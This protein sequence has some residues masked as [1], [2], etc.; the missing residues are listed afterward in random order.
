MDQP[1][2]DVEIDVELLR[3]LLREQ[4]P[5]LSALPLRPAGT[6]WDNVVYRLGE[7]LALRLP[8]ARRPPR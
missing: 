1:N 6:G 4:H 3:G 5:D 7:G 8:G 2:A